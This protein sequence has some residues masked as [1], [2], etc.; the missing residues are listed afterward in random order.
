M[1]RSIQLVQQL[2][3]HMQ[4]QLKVPKK[5]KAAG[6][7]SLIHFFISPEG[8]PGDMDRDPDHHRPRPR[9][10]GLGPCGA[11]AI[12]HTPGKISLGSEVTHIN[13][14]HLDI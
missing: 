1:P 3:T 9:A 13:Y 5:P 11:I 12:T 2:K 7:P 8:I 6:K 14:T 4:Q 10:P